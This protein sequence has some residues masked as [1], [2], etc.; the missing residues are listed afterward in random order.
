[1]LVRTLVIGVA[2]GICGGLVSRVRVDGLHWARAKVNGFCILVRL[3]LR[4]VLV[5]AS[6]ESAPALAAAPS[7]GLGLALL[8][9]E[10]APLRASESAPL[11]TLELARGGN[12]DSEGVSGVFDVGLAVLVTPT[13]RSPL[14]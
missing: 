8:G 10:L 6:T 2:V 4:H 7:S 11:S 5:S 12:V 3:G 14:G 9:P 13:V 1:V